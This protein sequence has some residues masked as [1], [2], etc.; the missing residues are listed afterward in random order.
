VFSPTKRIGINLDL[1]LFTI[2]V[3][4]RS[5]RSWCLLKLVHVAVLVVLA[6]VDQILAVYLAKLVVVATY[7]NLKSYKSLESIIV[8]LYDQTVYTSE[9]FVALP[10]SHRVEVVVVSVRQYTRDINA[11]VNSNL[12]I[13]T[14]KRQNLYTVSLA[15]LESCIVVVHDEIDILCCRLTLS[16]LIV[17][18]LS[19]RSGHHLLLSHVLGSCSSMR[20]GTLCRL[21][22]IQIDKVLELWYVA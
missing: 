15:H 11:I 13:V 2:L 17:M 5:A 12:V 22:L 8:T 18:L 1:D 9:R 10:R 21:Y 3:F 16:G 19:S 4:E 6:V 20:C 14:I 7:F